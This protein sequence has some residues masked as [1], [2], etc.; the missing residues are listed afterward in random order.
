M[1]VAN[2]SEGSAYCAGTTSASFADTFGGGTYD[3]VV[4]KLTSRG[5]VE[6]VTHIGQ[7][8]ASSHSDVNDTSG[9]DIATGIALDT[10]GNIFISGYTLGALGEANGGT[11]DIFFAKLN[12]R[13]VLQWLKQ[14]GSVTEGTSVA[15]NST[16]GAEATTGIVVD[17]SGNLYASGYT[18]DAL[19]EAAGGGGLYDAFIIKLDTSGTVLWL[20]HVGDTTEGASG[21]VNDT[22]ASELCHGIA[23]NP[24]QDR[25]YCAGNTSGAYAEATG[26]GATDAFVLGLNAASGAV[27]SLWQVGAATV[28]ASAPVLSA[29]GADSFYSVAVDSG[30]NVI[31]GGTTTSSFAETGDASTDILLVKWDNAG[32]ILWAS[33]VGTDT[34]TAE[35]TVLDTSGTDQC[36]AVRIDNDGNVY[37]GGYTNAGLADTNGGIQDVIIASFTSSGAFRWIQQFGTNKVASGALTEV[38]ADDQCLGLSVDSSGN[39]Y[40]GGYTRGDFKETQGTGDLGDFLVLRM[41]ATGEFSE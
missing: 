7:A 34:E 9:A 28:I 1:A 24:D 13:G 19:G 21:L 40:C 5:T 25:V 37:C 15:V 26:G 23:L 3:A 18:T 11:Y 38:T 39:V 16:A 10:A 6:W 22:S 29:A 35:S 4:F 33:Q 14:I 17:D 8:L 2:D 27:D 32:N 20:T 36:R 12:S 41:S 31:T 30:G